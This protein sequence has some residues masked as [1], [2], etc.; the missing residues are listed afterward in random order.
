LDARGI[1]KIADFGVSHLFEEDNG[2][3]LHEQAY[4]H[5]YNGKIL[6]R[7][8]SDK[9][10]AMKKLSNV[11]MLNKTEGTWCFW[12]P[13]M[14]TGETFSGY[15]A[16]MWAAGICLYIFVTG[17]LPFYSENPCDLFK[18]I[19]E[20]DPPFEGLGLSASLIDLLISTLNKNPE[21][22]A[23]VG[24]CLHHPFLRVARERRID[25]LS[26]AFEKS[27]KRN[28]IVDDEDIRKVSIPLL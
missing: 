8:D 2:L 24:D 7:I 27:R 12:S 25:Q 23:G 3:D 28:L 22:R 17:K 16:D 10:F 20:K 18:S 4:D 19:I 11:G 5:L 15:A 9:A 26:V 6:S 13:Q 14:C 1:V 21:E